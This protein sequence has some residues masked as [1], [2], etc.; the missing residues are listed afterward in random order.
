LDRLLEEALVDAYGEDEQHGAVL[1]MLEDRVPCPFTALV[2]G[3]RSRS[4]GS[5]GPAHATRS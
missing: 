2:V 1:V 4:E 3:K 5:T